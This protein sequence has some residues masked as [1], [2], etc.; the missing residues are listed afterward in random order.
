M[1]TTQPLTGAGFSFGMVLAIP[2]H[3]TTGPARVSP[4]EMTPNMKNHGIQTAQTRALRPV[5]AL[6][7]ASLLCWTSQ[8]SATV[9]CARASQASAKACASKAAK[10][11][12]AKQKSNAAATR[13][14]RG[15]KGAAA[16]RRCLA[17][18]LPANDKA[19]AALVPVLG[20][21]NGP[22]TPCFTALA[23]SQAAQHMAAKVPFFVGLAAGAE[24]LDNPAHA[25]K[26][27]Q[28]ELSSLIAGYEMCKEMS[29]PGP[30]SNQA[31]E[32]PAPDDAQWRA[33]KSILDGLRTGK[34]SYGAAA[35]A[36]AEAGQDQPGSN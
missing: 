35:R 36:L 33:S 24:V 3:A 21:A 5:L 19:A 23:G 30:G 17:A 12:A 16:Q 18:P 9:N 13:R 31:G 10:K 14:C 1:V 26:K 34:L 25:S 2:T 27:E 6:L 28:A 32:R 11:P 15:A 29:P 4:T 7:L 22:T 20:T 8:A